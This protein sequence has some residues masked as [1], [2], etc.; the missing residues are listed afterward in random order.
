MKLIVFGGCS[1]GAGGPLANNLLKKCVDE[2]AIT[3]VGFKSTIKL[4]PTNQWVKDFSRLLK[5]GYTVIGACLELKD[6]YESE[7]GLKDYVISGSK[8]TKLV[9]E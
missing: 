7:T 3:A 5:N 9:D 4:G 1:T 6:D 2:G 8:T